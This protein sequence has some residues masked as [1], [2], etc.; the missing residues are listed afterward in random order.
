MRYVDTFLFPFLPLPCES[1]LS[2]LGTQNSVNC[3]RKKN[4]KVL[5]TRGSVS[6]IPSGGLIIL[7]FPDWILPS[8]M[9]YTLCD[10]TISLCPRYGSAFGSPVARVQGVGYVQELVARLTHTPINNHV[11][12]TNSTLDDNPITFPLNQS[13]YVDATHEVVV[14]N[15]KWSRDA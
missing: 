12:S 11:F 7:S 5:T 4:G 9:D 10:V 1:R 8:G 13:L 15:G 6:R 3:L 14:L 2:Q